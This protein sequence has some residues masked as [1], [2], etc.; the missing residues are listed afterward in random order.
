MLDQFDSDCDDVRPTMLGRLRAL[1]YCGD[2]GKRLELCECND[3]QEVGEDVIRRMAGSFWL[4]GPADMTWAQALAM[5]EE[6][7]AQDSGE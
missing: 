5:A 2:C 3:E 6:H 1:D 7:F 4:H